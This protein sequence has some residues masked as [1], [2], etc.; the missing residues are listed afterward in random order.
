MPLR[1][2]A[3][4]N[5]VASPSST[6]QS[7]V[8]TGLDP[9]GI[10]LAP[11]GTFWMIDEENETFLHVSRDGQI[12]SRHY[13]P[14]FRGSNSPDAAAGA[15]TRVRGAGFEGITISP[16]GNT[17][18]GGH[19][20]AQL[21]FPA[22][23]AD[24]TFIA[25]LPRAD[26]YLAHVQGVARSGRLVHLPGGITPAVRMG[27]HDLSFDGYDAQGR[28]QIIYIERDNK[29]D[30]EAR[31]KRI[32][33]VTLPD[34][35]TYDNTPVAKELM[36]DLV[37]QNYKLEK[38][39]GLVK[40]GNR[41]YIVNDNVQTATDPME[42]TIVQRLVTPDLVCVG[43]AGRAGAARYRSGHLH[44]R[45]EQQQRQ[46]RHL[47]R[48]RRRPR[49]VH[50]RWSNPTTLSLGSHTVS[51]LGTAVDTSTASVHLVRQRR[52]PAG[53]RRSR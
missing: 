26:E 16:D 1:D 25:A 33:R 48:R 32:Y 7:V 34:Y 36:V 2:E 37:A 31:D 13:A 40:R 17:V 39:E 21:T 22:G 44:R 14:G 38:P 29:R 24:V 20:T 28:E 23:E 6:T 11:D 51:V 19:Q 10:A 27:M 15:A 53:F 49:V 52:R 3:G 41:Y 30:A 35:A 45:G 43:S 4:N 42:F 50:V 46:G 47:H 18:Y 9:E 8:T 5:V 12:I